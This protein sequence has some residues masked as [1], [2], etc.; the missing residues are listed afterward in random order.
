MLCS[1]K[2]TPIV[3]GHR[4][5]CNF[6]KPHET[7]DSKI[8]FEEAGITIDEDNKWLILMRTVIHYSKL[9]K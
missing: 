8:P 9:N 4:S 1:E 6:V 5:Y 3:E 7:L 2:S